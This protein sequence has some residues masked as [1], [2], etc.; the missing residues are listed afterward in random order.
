MSAGMAQSAGI[1]PSGPILLPCG[2][3]RH[4]VQFYGHDD[5]LADS[6]GSYL[7]DA[8]AGGSGVVLI[9]TAAHRAAF[10]SRMAAAGADLAA[11]TASGA[12]TALD[13]VALMRGFLAGDRDQPGGFM[14]VITEVLRRATAAGPAV[15]FGEITARL[16]S[17]GHLSAAAELE[18]AWSELARSYPFSLVCAYPAQDCPARLGEVAALHSAVLGWPAAGPPGGPAAVR[19]YLRSRGAP[20]AARHFV[21]GTLRQWGGAWDDPVLAVDAGIVATELATNAV[22]HARSDFTIEVAQRPGAVRITV[23]D[24]ADA[25]LP[26]VAVPGH[27]LSVLEKVAARWAAEPL[28]AGGKL[29]WAQLACPR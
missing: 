21:T 1:A 26:L 3:T 22:V 27:G 24:T 17:G 14:P 11:A 15:V 6:V 9:A 18:S 19:S 16:W 29:V 10:E 2:N 23:R 4:E 5:E 25:G 20:R 8:L 28:V 7:G 13:A 12:Y